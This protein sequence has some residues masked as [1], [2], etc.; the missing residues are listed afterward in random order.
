MIRKE[1]ESDVVLKVTEAAEELIKVINCFISYILYFKLFKVMYPIQHPKD[2]VNYLNLN[3]NNI[4]FHLQTSGDWLTESV[5]NPERANKLI[6][7][8]QVAKENSGFDSFFLLME[9]ALQ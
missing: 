1:D 6:F 2:I 8:A 7:P 3:G 4:R 9:L 5:E